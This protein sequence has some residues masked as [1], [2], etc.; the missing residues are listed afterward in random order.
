MSDDCLF[1]KIVNGEISSSIIFED[2]ISMAFMD[3]F[4]VNRGHCLLIPKQHYVNLLDIDL[5]VLGEVSKRLALLTRK[6]YNSIEPA[7][8]L[9]AITNGKGAGQEVFHIH[10]H[11]IPRE[12][13]DGFATRMVPGTN[14]EMAPREE[15]DELAKLIRET[16]PQ[17]GEIT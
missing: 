7:G 4:P 14:R 9:N 12:P 13:G 1:C 10:F 17:I 3:I 15:L 8:I 11:V 6:V 16:E 2:D 5:G